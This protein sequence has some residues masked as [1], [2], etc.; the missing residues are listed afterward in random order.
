MCK[1]PHEQIKDENKKTL[2]IVITDKNN[3]EKQSKQLSK[4][5]QKEK[6]DNITFLVTEEGKKVQK[7]LFKNY[8]TITCEKLPKKNIVSINQENTLYEICEKLEK[9]ISAKIVMIF[10][11]TY[12]SGIIDTCLHLIKDKNP[13]IRLIKT[14]LINEDIKIIDE[15][16][17]FLNYRNTEKIIKKYF[18]NYNFDLALHEIL[19]FKDVPLNKKEKQKMDAYFILNKT[20]QHFDKG[21]YKEAYKTL[22]KIKKLVYFEFSQY[23]NQIRENKKALEIL[24]DKTNKN[25]RKYQ[26]ADLINDAYRR[27]KEKKYD[28]AITRLYR[29]LGLVS[30]IELGE[31]GVDPLNIDINYIKNQMDEKIFNEKFKYRLYY[32][33]INKKYVTCGLT[34]NMEL[35]FQLRKYSEL[36]QYY[37]QNMKRF[38]KI[39]NY[40]HN[41]KYVH[42]YND[43]KIDECIDFLEFVLEF[44]EIIDPNM[45]DIINQ[46]E[47]LEL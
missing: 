8:E 27:I 42:G 39:T 32:D 19:E 43:A 23:K 47:F 9:R 29:A 38:I 15:N 5:I 20:Y 13:E 30:E 1:K 14:E 10:D 22:I 28:D 44:A 31:I 12:A 2:V 21:E 33:Q 4:L 34:C 6:P 37:K 40:R 24:S 18:N 46:T 36:G 25:Y 41:N 3:T 16:L 17:D 45:E 35:I 26:L 7:H 11:H